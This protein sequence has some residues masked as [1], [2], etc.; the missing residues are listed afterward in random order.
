MRKAGILGRASFL[1]FWK[2]DSVANDERDP[3]G[4]CKRC[5]GKDDSGIS[6]RGSS[7]GRERLCELSETFVSS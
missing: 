7:K 5:F 3:D 1:S 2:L 4:L 6:D